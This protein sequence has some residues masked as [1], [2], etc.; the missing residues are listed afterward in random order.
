MLIS[1]IAAVLGGNFSEK[2][3]TGV[4]SQLLVSATTNKP[5]KLWILYKRWLHSPSLLNG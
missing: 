1:G 3:A 5:M 4:K 2:N